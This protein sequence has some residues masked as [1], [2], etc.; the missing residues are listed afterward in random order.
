MFIYEYVAYKYRK[1]I[2]REEEELL[3][4]AGNRQIK[5]M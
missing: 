4:R 5:Y 1:E 2:M 3:N